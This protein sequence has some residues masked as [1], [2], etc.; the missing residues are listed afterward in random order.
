[1]KVNAQKG[2]WAKFSSSIL[3]ATGLAVVL[4]VPALAAPKP[5][6]KPPTVIAYDYHSVAQLSDGSVWYWG[7]IADTIKD[8]YTLRDNTPQ[9]MP[10]LKDVADIQAFRDNHIL[11][12]KNGTVWEWGRQLKIL[13]EKPYEV[14]SEFPDPKRIKELS[15]IVKIAGGEVYSAIDKDGSVWV[16]HPLVF[17]NGIHKLENITDAKDISWDGK[18]GVNILREDGTVWKWTAYGEDLKLVQADKQFRTDKFTENNSYTVRNIEMNPSYSAVQIE[19]LKDVAALSKGQGQQNF[20]IAKD[21]TVWGWG[22]NTRGNLGL[23]AKT[24]FVNQPE[25]IKSLSDVS[26][27]AT[28]GLSTLI[29]KKDGSLWVL[30]HNIGNDPLESENVHKLRRID[31]IEKVTS[32]ALGDQHAVAI[33]EDGNLWAWGKNNA[34]QLGDASF[35]DSLTPILVKKLQ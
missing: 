29:L 5:D 11:L 7:G 14:V 27:I 16:W 19:G 1:M 8:K 34:G 15:N 6:V 25:K 21:G 32:I 28:N 17:Y 22:K 18:A 12:K 3:L 2:K 30:G 10:G 35:K 23:P 20:A 33:T 24:E 26:S 4:S 31:G 13:S 9:L